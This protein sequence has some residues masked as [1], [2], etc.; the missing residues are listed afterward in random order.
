VRRAAAPDDR[1]WL[2]VKLRYKQPEG[3]RSVLIERPFTGTARGFHEADTDFRFATS[4]AMTAMLLRNRDDLRGLRFEDVLDL[5]G[6]ALGADPHGHRA[7]FI[8][9][10]R[11]LARRRPL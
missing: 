3:D 7:G 4:V 2:T 10:V 11:H 9:L 1:E 5:A 6:S 8:E